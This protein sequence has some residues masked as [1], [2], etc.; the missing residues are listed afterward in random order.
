MTQPIGDVEKWR[1]LANDLRAYARDVSNADGRAELIQAAD[2]WD[3]L[4]AEAEAGRV[5]PALALVGLS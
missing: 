2:D 1:K 5:A 4:A 3:R